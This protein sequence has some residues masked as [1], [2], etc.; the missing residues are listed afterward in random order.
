[1]TWRPLKCWFRVEEISNF[2]TITLFKTDCRP[3]TTYILQQTMASRIKGEFHSLLRRRLS[4]SIKGQFI[5]CETLSLL[6]TNEHLIRIKKQLIKCRL[7]GDTGLGPRHYPT[8]S[9]QKIWQNTLCENANG[10]LLCWVF[11]LSFAPSSTVSNCIAES[12]T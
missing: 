11:F 1:M 9:W 8:N 10:K 3:S 4:I 5:Y 12:R 2:I 6:A 7:R